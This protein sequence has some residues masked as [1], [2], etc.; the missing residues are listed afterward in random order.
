MMSLTLNEVL[1]PKPV[2]TRTGEEIAKDIIER[3]GLI[4]KD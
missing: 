3:A 1:N 4:Q 2:D